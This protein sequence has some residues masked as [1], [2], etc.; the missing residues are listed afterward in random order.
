[1]DQNTI[2]VIGTFSIS[3]TSILLIINLGTKQAKKKRSENIKTNQPV[4]VDVKEQNIF[5]I[6]DLHLLKKISDENIE[7]LN[8]EKIYRI[9]G[10]RKKIITKQDT[11]LYSKKLGIY[12]SLVEDWV[13]LG[14]FSILHGITQEYI[15][16]LE[17]NG[18]KSTLDLFDQ[19]PEILYNQLIQSNS[20]NQLPTLGMIKHWIR[21]SKGAKERE[22]QQILIMG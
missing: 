21:V 22:N 9:E 3:I 1:M 10:L 12:K 11:D 14:E 8:K 5:V 20:I 17:R 6:S 18:I 15:D 2:L 7:L 16:L 13:R 4:I 19:D